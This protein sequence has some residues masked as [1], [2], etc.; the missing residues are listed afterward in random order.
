MEDLP[1]EFA[2]ALQAYNR[3]VTDVFSQ[4]LKTVAAE[5][6]KDRG[7]ENKLPLSGIGIKEKHAVS[8][9]Y[10]S[11]IN[12]LEWD[13]MDYPTSHLY[14]LDRNYRSETQ[15]MPCMMGR[16]G[17]PSSIQRLSWILNGCILY[18]MV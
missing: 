8:Y 11:F 3:Q 4:Y 10:T 1:D 12:A 5:P 13:V 15:S 16:L 6:E 14:F 9:L 7:E 18:G 17:V 2:E